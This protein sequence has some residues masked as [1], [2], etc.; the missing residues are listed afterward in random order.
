MKIW[1]YA[2]CWNERKM[3]PFYLKHYEKFCEKIIIY[4]NESSDGS[5]Q[6]IQ[7]HPKCELRTYRTNGQI[8]DRK[9]MEIKDNCWKEAKGKADYVIVGDIDEFLHHYN[10]HDFLKENKQRYSLFK[11]AGFQMVSDR[12]PRT[13]KPLTEVV[14]KGTWHGGSSKMILFDPNRVREMNYRPGCHNAEPDK[15]GE[16]WWFRDFGHEPHQSPLKLLHYK[17]LGVDYV[18]ER[19]HLMARRLSPENRRR[20]WG[21]HYKRP[22]HWIHGEFNK[23][24]RGA[25]QIITG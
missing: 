14:K 2:I 11:P 23:W 13:D 9:Y 18:C 4:D 1:A 15:K 3:L 7:N 16:K 12:F 17:F 6:L 10:I 20:G 19:Y 8:Q 21:F 24:R 22:Q 25:K 5:R